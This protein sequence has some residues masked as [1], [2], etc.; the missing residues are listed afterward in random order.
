M[1]N[2]KMKVS[3]ATNKQAGL[4][5]MELMISIGI[6]SVLLL[7]VVAGYNTV[8]TS[9][10]NSAE[11]KNI[12]S[13]I[14]KVRSMFA[15]K[16]NYTGVSAG[17]LK[18]AG[19]IPTAMVSGSNVVHSWS[20]TAITIAAASPAT[21]FNLTYPAV[22]TANCIELAQTLSGSVTGITIGGTALG[23]TVGTNDANTLCSTTA[24][25]DMVFNVR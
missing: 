6:A 5:L 12:Q 21:S 8:K 10:E 9:S 11:I 3:M 2:S 15:G 14:S 13:I 7:A 24:T 23:T 17:M 1:I 18:N 20:D 4:G 25:A 16:N 19:G 22:P